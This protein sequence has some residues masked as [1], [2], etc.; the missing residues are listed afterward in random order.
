M[1]SADSAA[2]QRPELAARC[3]IA[4]AA[5]LSPWLIVLAC[6]AT[7]PDEASFF[8][9]ARVLLRLAFVLRLS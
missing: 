8:V 9:V 6:T 2:F 4:S 3:A 5:R 7:L 1:A